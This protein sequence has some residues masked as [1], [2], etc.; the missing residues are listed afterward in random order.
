MVASV[1]HNPLRKD[2]VTSGEG[3]HDQVATTPARVLV[4]DDEENIRDLVATSLRYQGY[5]V[6]TAASGAEAL[7]HVHRARTNL[8]LLDLMMPVMDGQEMLAKAFSAPWLP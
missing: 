6:D 2:A 1:P 3:H 8:I 4:V 5:E 7:E